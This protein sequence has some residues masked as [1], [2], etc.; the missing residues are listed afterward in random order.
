VCGNGRTGSHSCTYAH[1]VQRSSHSSH[2]YPLLTL[3]HLRVAPKVLLTNE[4]AMLTNVCKLLFAETRIEGNDGV[5]HEEGIASIL[6][7][8]LRLAQWVDGDYVSQEECVMPNHFAFRRCS[9]VLCV[10]PFV[11]ATSSVL[12]SFLPL[13]F[14]RRAHIHSTFR[15]NSILL[16]RQLYLAHMD[17]AHA[18]TGTHLRSC[19]AAVPSK[20]SR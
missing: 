7:A 17:R 10:V 11:N 9:G 5:V 20:T 3:A 1:L 8:V 18:H 13:H 4:A 19:T 12:R 2:P 15:T 6:V 14:F 16:R